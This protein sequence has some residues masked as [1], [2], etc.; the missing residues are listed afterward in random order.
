M[1]IL[2]REKELAFTL[3]EMIVSIACA[4]FILAAVVAAS[5]S[6][7]RSY[8]AAETYS[9]TEGDQLRV[10]DYI[11]MDC[12]RAT[13][14]NVASVNN[15]PVLTLTVPVFYDPCN[16][17]VPVTPVMV[18]GVVTYKGGSNTDCAN[19]TITSVTVKYTQ[20]GTNVTREVISQNTN[21]TTSDITTAI[22]QNVSSF[23]VNDTDLTNWVS[24]TI[25]FFPTF[26]H[27][28]GS[29]TW[30]SGL[31]NPDTA[32]SNG[33]GANG[34]WYVINT[35]ATDPTTIGN[36]YF[37]S[38]GVYSLVQ[39][40]KATMVACKTFLRNALARN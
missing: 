20:S 34:D 30:R 38:G 28:A 16:G 33:V 37:R 11:A 40:E 25:M 39:N 7:Q 26:L 8:A 2:S 6:L 32:P 4:T 12:R 27:N 13:S 15:L 10:L 14:A 35:T 17:N 29:G 1:K 21:G 36:V 5:V 18:N 22:A 23:T 24:C 3:T 19:I 9:N 31:S